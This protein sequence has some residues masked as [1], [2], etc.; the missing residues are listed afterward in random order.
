MRKPAGLAKP[1]TKRRIT[2]D[3]WQLVGLSLPTLLWYLAICYIPMFGIVIAFKNYKVAPGQGFL[4]CLF[5]K[6]K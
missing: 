1:G 4:Y 5:V 3:D 2:L 6:S